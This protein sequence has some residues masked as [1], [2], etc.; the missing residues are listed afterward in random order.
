[1]LSTIVT[2]PTNRWHWRLYNLFVVASAILWRRLLYK[3][4]VIAVSGSLGKTTA[5]ECLVAILSSRF[6]IVGTIGNDNGRRG[7][8][9]LLLRARP[10]HRYIVAE[11]GIRE[12]GHMWRS[13]LL[14]LPDV[15]TIT[16]VAPQHL[17]ALRDLD[18]VAAEKSKLL[19]RLSGDGLAVLNKDDP[20][21][22][23]MATS[24][25]CHVCYF[26]ESNSAHF[27]AS[28]VS[29]DWPARLTLTVHSSSGSHGI[30]TQ[31]VGKHWVPSILAA[32]ATAAS[33]GVSLRESAEVLSGVPPFPARMQP[34]E[35]PCGATMI[36]DEYN[37]TVETYRTGIEVLRRARAQR[38]VA[39]FGRVH[40]HPGGAWAGLRQVAQ[41]LADAVEVAVFVGPDAGMARD[42]GVSSGMIPASTHCFPNG[43]LAARFLR[44]ELRTG[45]LV[46]LKGTWDDHLSRVYF[47]QL[48][49]VECWVTRC[50]LPDLCDDCA[51][52]KFRPALR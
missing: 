10:H 45:D 30:Q 32:V 44:K 21:V 4:R 2:P 25:D 24:R 19:A 27:W 28:D 49:T 18:T 31:L 29:S 41:E 11:V 42:A 22:A 46:L 8:P 7:L 48:G 37:G 47:A 9:R 20:R 33:C 6:P 12:P 43:E 38:R 1:M 52:L 51:Q 26:G 35:L 40:E 3:V 13:A 17:L 36:R 50:P 16:N 14:L 15:V 23:Y 5:K 34:V 39:V